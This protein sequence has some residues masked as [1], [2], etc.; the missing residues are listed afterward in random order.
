MKLKKILNADGIVI[1]VI[2]SYKLKDGEQEVTPEKPADPP[3]EPP[4]EPPVTPTVEPPAEPPVTPPTEPAEGDEEEV[5]AAVEKIT[6]GIIAKLNVGELT[7]KVE[8]LTADFAKRNS[9]LEKIFAGESTKA[10]YDGMTTNEKVVAFYQA[11][12]QA[13][14]PVLK[15]LSEGTAADG[16]YL[17]PDEF[18]YEVLRCIEDLGHMRKEVRVVPMKRDIMKIPTLESSVQVSWT[19]ENVAKSTTTA[20]FGEATL[21]VK[22]MA[23]ILYASDELVEDSSEIDVVKL[24]IELFAE[25]VGREEDRVIAVGNGTTQPT[26]L[27]TA[28]TAGTIASVAAAGNLSFDDIINLIY[29]LP[30]EHHANAKFY[31]N[32]TNI[33]ELRKLKDGD[34]RYLWADPVSKG[35]P[36][37]LYG[38]P[39]VEYNWLGEDIIFFG[40]LK[41]AY[42]LGDRKKM[43]VKVSQDTETAFTKDQ[44]AIRVVERIA[45]NVVLGCAVRALISIP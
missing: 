15:A 26:G 5:N 42:W 45:G 17:F 43:S 14:H 33:R 25:A 32:R 38:Y 40:D 31:V 16:G 4:V 20:H 6:K 35:V 23:A 30:K 18:R 27:V 37:T 36:P 24:I 7:K 29:L 19:E 11:A 3:A 10:D 1:E 2:D 9:K 34:N 22:K 8:T 28:R 13:N 21:T 41:K 12:I 39:V 44:T